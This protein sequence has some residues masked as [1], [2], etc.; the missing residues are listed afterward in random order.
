MTEENEPPPAPDS[1]DDT[2][3]EITAVVEDEVRYIILI[4][5]DAYYA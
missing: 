2:I 3:S 5:M 4:D 1:D